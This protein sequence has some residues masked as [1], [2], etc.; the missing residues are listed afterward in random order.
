[1]KEKLIPLTEKH[2]PG[3]GQVLFIRPDNNDILEMIASYERLRKELENVSCPNTPSPTL[4][5]PIT[6]PPTQ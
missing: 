2:R 5:S 4:H 1:M 6:H 3:R